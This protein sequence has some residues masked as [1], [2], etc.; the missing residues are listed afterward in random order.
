MKATRLPHIWR[1]ALAI[2]LPLG[3]MLCV[4][5]AVEVARNQGIERLT[6]EADNELRLTAASLRGQLSRHAY[7]PRLVAENDQLRAFLDH[8]GDPSAEV[9]LNQR[10]DR[11]RALAGV[12][13]LYLVD[14]RGTTIA[15]SNW[16]SPST[17]I[18]QNYRFRPY[19]KDAIGGGEGRFYGLGTSSGER[20]YFFSASVISP[21]G[22]RGVVVVKVQIAD[23]EASWLD[24]NADIMV[25]DPHGVIFIASQPSMVLHT[26]DPLSEATRNRLLDT[27]R[28]ANQRL[29][30]LRLYHR[31]ALPQ[32]LE[33]L[34]VESPSEAN[35]DGGA[36]TEVR[37]S[38]G[39]SSHDSAYDSPAELL[40]LT[41]G[42]L[43]R[44]AW[45]SLSR[46]LPDIGWRLHV[47]KPLAPLRGGIWQAAGLAAGVYA[48]LCLLAGLGWQRLRILRERQLFA[49]RE[50]L[51]LAASQQRVRGIIDRTRAGLCILDEHTRLVYLNPTAV[52]LFG[53]ALSSAHPP[54]AREGRDLRELFLPAE[55][56]QLDSL[57]RP[58]A[59]GP[60]ELHGLR[61]G[62]AIPLELSCSPLQSPNGARWLVTVFD[63]S[64][65]R[66]QAEALAQARDAFE[67]R[68]VERTRDLAASNA[69]LSGEVEER[70]RAERELRTT[71]DELIQTAKLAVLGELAAGINHELNQPLAAI[72]AYAENATAFLARG[73]HQQVDANLAQ[74]TELT[75][76]MGE[77]SAQLRQFSRKS[78]DRLEAV[79]LATSLNYALR[80]L[81][82]RSDMLGVVVELQQDGRPLDEQTPPLASVRAEPVRLEQVLVN[83]VGNALDALAGMPATFRQPRITITLSEQQMAPNASPQIVLEVH[84]NGPGLAP[85]QLARVFEPFYTQRAD[86]QGLGLGL[87]ISARIVNDLGGMLEAHPSPLGGALFRLTLPAALP[88]MTA[89]LSPTLPPTPQEST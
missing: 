85:A 11:M 71:R 21:S 58:H 73:Q 33:R 48:L 89:S 74:I 47:L 18:G 10:L 32:T 54:S 17:F 36:I 41:P 51:S 39:D 27:Q 12:S 62:M 83:L 53:A 52:E 57:T 66:A 77:I 64:E 55:R 9:A 31:E 81:H 6:H 5:Q 59:I 13:D 20:G 1:L 37:N 78:G 8:P 14:D 43:W 2:V 3:L 46:P 60:L 67:Q 35:D 7:L 29:L 30:P 45:L 49:K 68:V 82:A 63:V 56:Q 16:R 79:D 88:A 75:Q 44:H 24:Q 50:R 42:D 87:S 86:G 70:T 15:A 23:L 26:L 61:G 84:D 76:R 38:A 34:N 69:R 22:R 19:W 28:Y 25:T 65:R 4:W 80:L 72:R 40:Q